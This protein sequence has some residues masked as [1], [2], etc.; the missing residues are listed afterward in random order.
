LGS[1]VLRE[2]TPANIE[3]AAVAMGSACQPQSVQKYRRILRAILNYGCDLGYLEMAPKFKIGRTRNARRVYCWIARST[4][5]SRL[6]L[7]STLIFLWRCGIGDQ[8]RRVPGTEESQPEHL[9][10][11][12]RLPPEKGDT[13]E[14][15]LYR[16]RL[17]FRKLQA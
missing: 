11:V 16:R 14:G 12:T 15:H 13:G 8:H 2:I 3:A 9:L 6:R 10:T 7:R 1:F 5:C 4:S 17:R